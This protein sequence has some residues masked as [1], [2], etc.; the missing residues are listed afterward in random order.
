MHLT[1][2]NA[3]LR[4]GVAIDKVSSLCTLLGVSLALAPLLGWP[5]DGWLAL[6]GLLMLLLGIGEKYWAAR[7]ALDMDLFAALAKSQDL[8][9]AF[10]ELDL[11]LEQCGLAPKASLQQLAPRSLLSRS[12]GALR[13]LRYQ[14]LCVAGQVLLLLLASLVGCWLAFY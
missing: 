13:L 1:L 2:M 5:L 4:R 12:Q 10:A 11:A 9:Q 3:T 8:E 6:S 7:V 14:G